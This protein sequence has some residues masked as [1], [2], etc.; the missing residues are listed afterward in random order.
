[1]KMSD[2]EMHE[3]A[4]NIKMPFSVFIDIY[5]TVGHIIEAVLLVAWFVTWL[6]GIL[7]DNETLSIVGL[8]FAIINL[9]TSTVLMLVTRHFLT[10]WVNDE[11]DEDDVK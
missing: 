1:M 9:F 10:K 2:R 6:L 3:Q 7:L 4:K 8:V 5:N 11:E